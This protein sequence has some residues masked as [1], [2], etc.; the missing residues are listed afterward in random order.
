MR[1][2]TI[3]CLLLA[4]PSAAL[5]IQPH[6]APKVP[7]PGEPTPLGADD[8][9]PARVRRILEMREEYRV[10]VAEDQE[11]F[12]A[13][14]REFAVKPTNGVPGWMDSA[15]RV[16]TLSPDGD[17]VNPL[18]LGPWVL[19]FAGVAAALV[20]L[21]KLPP[22]W[23]TFWR[24]RRDEDQD[25]PRRR[26]ADGPETITLRPRETRWSNGPTGG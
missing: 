22:G 17:D 21:L 24:R 3:L 10:R 26:L 5:A 25:K 23:I 12:S 20:L 14:T 9:E 2:G 18:R 11:K 8:T 1:L 16:T 7:V 15:T 6:E 4:W 19:G 13:A